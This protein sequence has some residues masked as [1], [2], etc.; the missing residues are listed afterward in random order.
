MNRGRYSF[1][2]GAGLLVML[3]LALGAASCGDSEDADGGGD[4]AAAERKQVFANTPDGRIRATYADF[5]DVF[6][7]RDAQAIC[8]LMTQRTQRELAKQMRKDKSCKSRV[9]FYFDN[10]SRPVKDKPKILRIK[11]KGSRAVA[12]TQVKGSRRYPVSF[13]KEDGEWKLTDV[14]L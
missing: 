3:A 7:E 2:R 5:V 6:Y 1:A 9:G 12:V 14:G 4:A 8:D 13:A 11:I 10:G